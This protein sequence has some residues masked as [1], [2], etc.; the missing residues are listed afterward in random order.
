MPG[1][2][3]NVVIDLA[4]QTINHAAANYDLISNLTVT[5][6]YVTLNLSAGTLDLS[7]G[8]GQG[9]FKT[10][11]QVPPRSIKLRRSVAST[12]RGTSSRVPSS[13]QAPL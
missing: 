4:H 9:T 2:F 12:S 11:A 7:G 6:Q 3:D 13:P 1:P 10:A 8:G 5:G